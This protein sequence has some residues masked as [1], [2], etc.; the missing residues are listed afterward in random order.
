MTGIIISAVAIVAAIIYN[1]WSNKTPPDDG[2]KQDEKPDRHY[3]GN[4]RLPRMQNPPPPPP[5]RTVNEYS[6]RRITERLTTT[7]TRGFV[8]PQR[9]PSKPDKH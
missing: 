7:E 9:P 1:W 4:P 3:V 6:K 2:F 5:Q 8:R